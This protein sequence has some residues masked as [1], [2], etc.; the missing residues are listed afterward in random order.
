MWG[1]CCF[2]DE[3]DQL[4]GWVEHGV[5]GLWSRAESVL[6]GPSAIG[7]VVVSVYSIYIRQTLFVLGFALVA[8]VSC[9]VCIPNF[10]F[11]LETIEA[12]LMR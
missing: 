9:F 6:V 7:P 10:L 8:I 4:G 11:P 5:Q 12:R 2:G 1:C 3:E